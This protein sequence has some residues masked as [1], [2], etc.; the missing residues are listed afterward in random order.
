M[1]M[2]GHVRRSEVK[3]GYP[4]SKVA[5]TLVGAMKSGNLLCCPALDRASA[6]Y[7]DTIK[8]CYSR[9]HDLMKLHDT[10]IIK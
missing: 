10:D 7:D 6:A 1:G 3:G 4:K 8:D 9:N 2:K 5:V